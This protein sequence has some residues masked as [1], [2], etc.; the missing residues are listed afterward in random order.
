M[1]KRYETRTPASLSNTKAIKKITDPVELFVLLFQRV[2]M[3]EPRIP[4]TS[5]IS[6]AKAELF[7][8]IRDGKP[9]KFYMFWHRILRYDWNRPATKDA[10]TCSLNRLLFMGHIGQFTNRNDEAVPLALAVEMLAC[11]GEIG[12]VLACGFSE[13]GAWLKTT[14]ESTKELG[15]RFEM[16]LHRDD[17]SLDYSEWETNSGI[18]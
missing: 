8:A 4:V 10:E 17:N 12:G 5:Y 1:T 15:V 2:D 3:E 14:P 16:R 7:E 6:D 18:V 9:P 13:F 11:V